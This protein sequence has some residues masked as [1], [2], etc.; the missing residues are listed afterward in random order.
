MSKNRLCIFASGRG[1]NAEKIIEYFK[2]SFDTTI[3]LIVSNKMD[4]KVLD[5]A[6]VH[7]IPQYVIGN[8]KSFMQSDSLLSYLQEKEIT[9]IILAGFLWLIPKYLIQAYPDKIINIHPALLP[10]YGGKGMYGM[11]VHRAVKAA[12]ETTSGITIHLVNEKFDDGA[13]LAQ[14]ECDLHES[15]NAQEIA[16]K[17]LQLEHH[18]YPR[19]IETYLKAGQ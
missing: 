16:K 3:D 8:K 17:V 18:H 2:G 11:N 1:S 4:A 10:K 13:H 12:N 9:H 5:L 7:K 6:Q 14:L 19:V 15:D